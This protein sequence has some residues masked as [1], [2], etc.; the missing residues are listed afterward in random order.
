MFRLTSLQNQRIKE[1]VRLRQGKE[2][3][4]MHRF[5]IDGRREIRRA[6]SQKFPVEEIFFCPELADEETKNWVIQL[7]KTSSHAL[8]FWEVTENIFTKIAYGQ[9]EDGVLAVA[10]SVKKTLDDIYHQLPTNTPFR[11]AILEGVE[12]PG[13]VGAILRSADGAGISALILASP[14]TDL[15][16]PNTIRASLGTIFSVPTCVAEP[17]EIISWLNLHHI[18]PYA[19]RVDGAIPYTDADFTIPCAII[20]GS[21]AWG[22][23]S[24]FSGGNIQ[25]IFL[26][27]CGIADS[28]NV[29]TSAAILFYES[30]RQQNLISTTR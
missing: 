24:H 5:L 3:R 27:M 11:I 8:H 4:K 23:S 22:L 18:T 13:N 19:A 17:E 1:I 16:N 12:K 20:L 9:R 15:F 26:P 2:R 25:P 6:I 29:S 10:K 14:G 30:L 28:L 21:E 7:E